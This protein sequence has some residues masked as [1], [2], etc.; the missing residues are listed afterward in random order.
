MIFIK[1]NILIF[2][3]IGIF[4][5]IIIIVNIYSDIYQPV[6]Q[7]KWFLHKRHSRGTIM[8]DTV[9]TTTVLTKDT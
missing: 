9:Y 2:I 7:K 3:I 1:M 6:P 5:I 4:I 8:R